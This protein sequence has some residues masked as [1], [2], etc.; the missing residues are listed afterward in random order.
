MFD[1]VDFYKPAE[2]IY[3]DR[4]LD[5]DDSNNGKDDNDKDDIDV[6][7]DSK[8]ED[9]DDGL[10]QMSRKCDA[11]LLQTRVREFYLNVHK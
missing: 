10:S 7:D 2:N 11:S 4:R 5:D 1:N 8:E 3:F 6:E 9:A